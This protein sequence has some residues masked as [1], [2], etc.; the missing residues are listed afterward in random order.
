MVVTRAVAFLTERLLGICKPPSSP[1][2]TFSKSQNSKNGHQEENSLHSPTDTGGSTGSL[3]GSEAWKSVWDIT[4][5]Y[6]ATKVF[7]KNT[8]IISKMDRSVLLHQPFPAAPQ[9]HQDPPPHPLPPRGNRLII[10][11]NRLQ[12]LSPYGKRIQALCRGIPSYFAYPTAGSNFLMRDVACL[13]VEINELPLPNQNGLQQVVDQQPSTSITR[14]I[15][16]NGQLQLVFINRQWR[17]ATIEQ[18]GGF[19]SWKTIWDYNT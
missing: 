19:R 18:Q 14:Q 17:V 7:S 13:T 8:C 11:T 12:S 10:S 2:L 5:G 4:T 6:V 15:T 1:P 9:G 16:I 3:R